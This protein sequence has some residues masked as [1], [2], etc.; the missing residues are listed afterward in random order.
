MIGLLVARVAGRW[1][2]LLFRGA[3][4][5]RWEARPACGADHATRCTGPSGSLPVL[6]FR[7]V[8]PKLAS[9]RQGRA[10]IRGRLRSSAVQKGIAWTA[11]HTGRLGVFDEHVHLDELPGGAV[12]LGDRCDVRRLT[13]NGALEAGASWLS[14]MHNDGVH[15]GGWSVF[16]RLLRLRRAPQ[17]K[18]D[19][20]RSCL[21]GGEAGASS[22]DPAFRE[23]QQRSPKDRRR[24]PPEDRPPADASSPPQRVSRSTNQAAIR[25]KN[26]HD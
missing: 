22:A 11:P 25:G 9:L 2:T 3:L 21:S 20:G 4:S 24:L 23:E 17:R 5:G 19:Q 18:A 14:G 13:V 16:G 12:R 6:A 26:T 10:L 8:P 7:G 15:V 1:G